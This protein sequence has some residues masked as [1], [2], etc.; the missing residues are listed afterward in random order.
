M[1]P[2]H[3]KRHFITWSE[4]HLCFGPH[5]LI[6]NLWQPSSIQ[7]TFFSTIW[8]AYCTVSATTTS[9]A[10]FDY[11][12]RLDSFELIV[13][14]SIVGCVH[15]QSEWS[16]WACKRIWVF[17]HWSAWLNLKL[18]LLSHRRGNCRRLCSYDILIAVCRT[19][20]SLSR[21][22]LHILGDS[23]G[24]FWNKLW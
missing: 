7:L 14:F 2:L 17:L 11:H 23:N 18:I 21:A 19:L 22:S 10:D 4:R 1:T 9:E 8:D 12:F 13:R 24:T 15:F 3:R 16:F 20:K 5:L 6:L